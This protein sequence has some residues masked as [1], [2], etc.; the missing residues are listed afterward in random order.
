MATIKVNSA[1]M[2]EK[3]N[4]L[5]TSSNS[6]KTFTTD[7]LTEIDNLKAYWEGEAAEALVTRF[8]GLTNDFEDI[9]KTINDYALFLDNAADAYDAT[10]Q[11]I[12]AGAES[13][14]S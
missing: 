14:A 8:K 6:I 4:D 1:V 10:E 7:M 13:Q 12:T 11:A 5:R 3:A 2:R 9:Y